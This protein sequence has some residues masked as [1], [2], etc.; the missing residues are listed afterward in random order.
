MFY[1]KDIAKNWCVAFNFSK[2]FYYK[3]DGEKSAM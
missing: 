1:I 3:I 2:H